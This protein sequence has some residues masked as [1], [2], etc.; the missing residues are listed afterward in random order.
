MAPA[1]PDLLLLVKP[2]PEMT[3]LLSPLF[4]VHEALTPAALDAAISRIG[5]QARALFT[6]SKRPV[7][8][9]LLARLP[10]LEHV[11]VGG[12]HLD[13]IDLAACAGRGIAVSY[14]PK[15]SGGDVADCAMALLLDAARGIAHSD[16]HVRAGRWPAEGP[17]PLGKR[18]SG[19]RLGL[20]GLGYIGRLIADRARGFAMTVAYTARAAKAD[21]DYPFV[22]DVADLA[23]QSDFLV[24]AAAT[25]PATRGAVD[26]RVLDALG[27]EGVL[28]NI[29]RDIVDEGAL[30]AALQARRIRAAAIDVFATEPQVPPAFLALDNVVVTSHIGSATNAS[31][32]AMADSAIANLSAHFAGRP[33]PNPAPA[34]GH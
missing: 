12:G 19:A 26:G 31:R 16:R 4:T 18:V 33:V 13:A 23:R 22:A 8:A 34:G 3:A 6:M 28:V 20:Y 9:A 15:L 27:P 21:V 24:I 14:T 7:D 25:T 32:R 5:G 11:A 30:I 17:T 10:A 1:K 2:V 29:C